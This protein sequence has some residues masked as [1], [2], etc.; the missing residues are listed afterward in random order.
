MITAMSMTISINTMVRN[1]I[2]LTAIF[3]HMTTNTAIAMTEKK[4]MIIQIHMDLMIMTTAIMEK[5]PMIIH[6]SKI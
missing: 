1:T 5:T 2:I 3:M 4:S 6:I